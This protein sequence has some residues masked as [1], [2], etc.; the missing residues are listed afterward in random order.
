MIKSIKSKI[1]LIL[2]V[3]LLL[4]IGNSFVSINYFNK[5][6]QSIDSIMHANYDSVVA[7]Q[8]MIESIE[9]QDSL[10][11]TFLFEQSNTLSL[12]HEER[13]VDFIEWLYKAKNNITEEGE[14]VI[15]DEINRN[16]TEYISKVRNLEKMKSEEGDIK[17][18]QYYYEEILPLFEK[19][20]SGCSKLLEINQNSMVEMKEESRL[21]ANE[22]CYYILAI[23]GIVIIIGLAIIGYLLKKIINPIEALEGGIKEVSKGNY[24]YLIPLKKDKEIN[25]ILTEFNNMTNKLEEYELLNV[26]EILREKQ[27]GEAII[28]SIDSPIII[29]DA[30]NKVTMINKAAERILDIKEKNVTSRHFLEGMDSREIFNI[31]QKSQSSSREF[32]SEDDIEFVIKDK[33]IYFRVTANPIWFERNENIGTVTLMQDVTTFKEIQKLKSEF[34]STVSHEFRTPLTS[35]CMAVELLLEREF[36]DIDGEMELLGIIKE[37][38]ERLDRLVG[39]L[40][41]LSKMEAGKIEMDMNDVD[42][43]EVIEPVKKVLKM[44]LEERRI[45][46]SLDINGLTRKVKADSNK[47]SWVIVNLVGNAL[48]YTKDDGSGKIEIKTKQVNND[49]LVT[50]SDNGQ[51][52][53]EENQKLIFE[54][55]IQIKDESG[56]EVGSSGLGLA[57]CKEIVKAHR[58]E[59]WVDSTLGEGSTFYFTLKLGGVIDEEENI[60]C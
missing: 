55:F 49:M 45:S 23:T 36:E 7:A 11:L 28:E 50:I 56:A 29:T 54:K 22:A 5:L 42:I 13:H 2:I 17:A 57:I 27:K 35:I 30:D 3:F 9:R 10:E 21:L 52:I 40:L 1:S 25:Y 16:Y 53:S 58:G 14:S 4:T 12:E 44:Q 19:L 43:K 32:K 59:I 31:I 37:D 15:V 39:E 51:G 33:S 60:D 8:N 41:D 38:S 20:K 47:I 26:N 48:R 6:Q 46:L 34:I 18:K 24:K